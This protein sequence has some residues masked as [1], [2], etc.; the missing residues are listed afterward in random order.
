MCVLRC[1]FGVF[2][3]V[4]F[5]FL[6]LFLFGLFKLNYPFTAS[7]TGFEV[8][9]SYLG[10]EQVE[11]FTTSLPGV[12]PR[13]CLGTTLSSVWLKV[14]EVHVVICCCSEWV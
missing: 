14:L 2:G 1:W 7:E 8:N 10:V 11:H 12:P 3:V 4:P 9:D 5:S 13:K 6:L